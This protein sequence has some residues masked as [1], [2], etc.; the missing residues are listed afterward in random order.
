MHNIYK[1]NFQYASSHEEGKAA[2]NFHLTQREKNDI[3]KSLNSGF[4]RRSVQLYK[5]LLATVDSV[6]TK[7]E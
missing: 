4:N 2:L 3:L 5:Q 1:I 6:N 7:V